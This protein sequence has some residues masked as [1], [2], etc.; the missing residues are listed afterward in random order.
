MYDGN[1]ERAK[2]LWSNDFMWDDWFQPRQFY[3]IDRVFAFCNRDTESDFKTFFMAAFQRFFESLTEPRGVFHQ[4]IA[5][6]YNAFA[7]AFWN[8]TDIVTRHSYLVEC[9][10]RCAVTTFW[11]DAWLEIY[12]L[13]KQLPRL[14]TRIALQS[15]NIMLWHLL[16][17]HD[18]LPKT[19]KF[20]HRLLS[21]LKHLPPRF[22]IEAWRRSNREWD[23]LREEVL[24]RSFMRKDHVNATRI[25]QETN[26]PQA[27]LLAYFVRLAENGAVSCLNCIREPMLICEQDLITAYGT[28]I[29]N[30][31]VA[32][33]ACLWNLHPISPAIFNQWES[34][35]LNAPIKLKSFLFLYGICQP[36]IEELFLTNKETDKFFIFKFLSQAQCPRI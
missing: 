13:V 3:L 4:L 22:L 23:V 17:K 12:E 20:E 16:C 6:G 25:I 26:L 14:F 21:R 36:Q 8:K 1:F 32:V 15:R 31:N 2:L 5:Y 27:T 34:R 35:I 28:A 19:Q 24:V 30:N 18:L 29:K 9:D 11:C 10:L 33:I 7:L